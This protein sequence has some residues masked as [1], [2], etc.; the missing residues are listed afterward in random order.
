VRH[1][2]KKTINT[3]TDRLALVVSIVEPILTVPQVVQIFS[4]GDVSGIS[5]FTWAG[6]MV[7]AVIWLFYGIRHKLTAI[8]ISSALWVFFEGLVVVGKIIYS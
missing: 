7:I 1:F 8:I 3:W 6:Y 4:T 2:K 5:L